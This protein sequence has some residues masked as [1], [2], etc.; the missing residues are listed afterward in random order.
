MERFKLIGMLALGALVAAFAPPLRADDGTVT[1]SSTSSGGQVYYSGKSTGVLSGSKIPITSVS[2]NSLTPLGVSGYN[3]GTVASHYACGQLAFTT[4]TLMSSTSTT[5]V[6]NGGGTLTISGEIPGNTAVV[7]LVTAYFSGPVTMT[8]LGNNIWQAT[9]AITVT[10]VDQSLL[11]AFPGIAVPA[12]GD[13]IDSISLKFI[14]PRTGA[15]GGI[16]LDPSVGIAAVASQ[17]PS[18]ILLLG[19]GLTALGLLLRRR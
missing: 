10:A 13:V 9:G 8:Y 16:S 18:A 1:F 3:C 2:F 15:I 14:S 11:A 6:F 19:S 17:E 12:P 7:T 5:R 4:G